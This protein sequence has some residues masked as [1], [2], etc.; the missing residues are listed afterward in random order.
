MVKDRIDL[1]NYFRDSGFEI[2]AEIGVADGRYAEILLQ[3]M[4][5]M[6]Y[7]GVDVW[8][9]YDGNWRSDDYQEQAYQKAQ[10]RT[11]P[12][13][14]ATLLRK[15]SLLA[16]LEVPDGSLDFVFIDGSHTFDNVMLDILLWVPK[17]RKGGIVSGHDYY[18]FHDS[19]IVEA[20]NTYVEKH[21]INLNLTL[22]GV[23]EHKDDQCPCWWF[24]KP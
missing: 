7:Y 20:V 11:A 13:R 17:V 23:A 5:N 22:Q 19:G 21:K 14:R 4:P 24:I 8:A 10:E 15:T 1:A 6:R 16:S 2:G 3:R 12:Y 18:Q 9:K